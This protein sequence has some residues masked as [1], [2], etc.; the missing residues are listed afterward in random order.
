MKTVGKNTKEYK[1]AINEAK[2]VSV[3]RLENDFH[4]VQV[5]A[6]MP[7]DIELGKLVKGDGKYKLRVHSNLWYEWAV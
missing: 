6:I 7:I 2:G 4:S 3:Y 5:K 1:K